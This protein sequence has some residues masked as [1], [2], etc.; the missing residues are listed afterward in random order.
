MTCPP[1]T[2]LRPVGLGSWPKTPAKRSDSKLRGLPGAVGLSC[3]LTQGIEFSR[4]DVGLKLPVP[5]CGVELGEPLTKGSE[6]V[7]GQALNLTFKIS[8]PTH[9][10]PLGT[11]PRIVRLLS[12]LLTN[13][14]VSILERQ[15]RLRAY[16]GLLSYPDRI[17][18]SIKMRSSQQTIWRGELV[19]QPD[20]LW[21]VALFGLESCAATRPNEFGPTN[22]ALRR[23][24]FIRTRRYIAR[25][26]RMNSP[27]RTHPRQPF[28]NRFTTSRAQASSSADVI[29]APNPM[30]RRCGSAM[31]M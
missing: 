21:S 9:C 6:L 17:I 2:E 3:N 26:G 1:A 18:M 20:G 22:R 13:E 25:G 29:G 5:C 4:F 28:R 10:A 7:G 12:T 30:A 14:L 11:L 19:D 15:D 8:N 31:I 24:E 23:C 16:H 27:Y